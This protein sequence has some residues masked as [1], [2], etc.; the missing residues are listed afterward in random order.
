MEE[1]TRG[2]GYVPDI[3]N[4]NDYT[5]EHPEI[6]PLLASTKVLKTS[7][8]AQPTSAARGARAAAAPKVAASVDLRSFCSPVE[9]QGQLGS[10]TANAAVGLVEFF[11]NKAFN[12]CID[13]S[14]LFVYK[15]TR[16]LLQWTGDTGATIRATM[17][18]LVLVGAP[19]EKYWPY[20]TAK[21]DMEPPMVCYGLAANWKA[22]KYFRLDPNGATPDQ[23]LDNVKSYLAAGYP[24]MFGFPVYAEFM[25]VGKNG[26]VPLPAKGS[27]YYGGH[28]IMAVGYDDKIQVGPDKGALLIRNSWGTG[29]GLKGYAWLG[30]KY[31]TTGLAVDW[32]T[33]IS[34]G[35]VDTGNF[36]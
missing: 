14:R 33:M 12:K 4:M 35:W 23:V 3:P 18:A 28:A 10:C 9:D 26:V 19:P 25:S 6:S 1:F 5:E 7:G 36:S 2:L 16:D 32:W 34:Q 11:E 17:G 22:A 8:G 15:M 27:K 21:F 20:N 24:S 29:W 31:V 30:Y 13:A